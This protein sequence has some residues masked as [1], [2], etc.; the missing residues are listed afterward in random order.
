M[1]AGARVLEL[2]ESPMDHFV[3]GFRTVASRNRDEGGEVVCARGR[4]GGP[5]LQ[6]GAGVTYSKDS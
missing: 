6:G 1:D 4:V 2:R 3:I 5:W